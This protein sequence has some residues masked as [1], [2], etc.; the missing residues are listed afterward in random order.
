MKEEKTKSELPGFTDFFRITVVLGFLSTLFYVYQLFGDYAS[1][2]GTKYAWLAALDIGLSLVELVM[3]LGMLIYI[4]LRKRTFLICFWVDFGCRVV[5]LLV[6]LFVSGNV[7]G[8]LAPLAVSLIWAAYFYRSNNFAK[9]FTPY[10]EPFFSNA[11]R[12]TSDAPA[13]KAENTSAKTPPRPAPAKDAQKKEQAP[14]SPP[15]KQESASTAAPAH[16]CNAQES[17]SPPASAAAGG[18]ASPTPGG[19]ASAVPAPPAPDA[20][21]DPAAER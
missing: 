10:K 19:V 13:P 16:A 17:C 20:A 5:T 7:S 9:A 2:W 11:P 12:V 14:S 18:V 6:V 21:S 8:L 1:I 4:A 3:Y 15:Q